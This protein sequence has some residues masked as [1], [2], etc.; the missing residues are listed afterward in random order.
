MGFPFKFFGIGFL[1]ILAGCTT[2]GPYPN[3]GAPYEIIVNEAGGGPDTPPRITGDWLLMTVAYAGGCEDH[4]FQLETFARRDTSHVWLHHISNNDNCEAHIIDD[5]NIE[6]PTG[7][8][9][10]RVIAIHDP[11]GSMPHLIK[12]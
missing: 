7:V 5:L 8:Q 3:F 12:W 4:E 10:M 11:N 6:L 9:A 1:L 2:E